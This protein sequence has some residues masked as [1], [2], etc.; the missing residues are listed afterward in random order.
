MGL[1]D[2][3][4]MRGRQGPKDPYWDWLHGSDHSGSERA[5]ERRATVG[6]ALPLR[7]QQSLLARPVNLRWVVVLAMLVGAFLLPHLTIAGRH[8]HIWLLP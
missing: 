2:R 8:W 6:E 1:Y 5:S 4:Y 7:G 3:D